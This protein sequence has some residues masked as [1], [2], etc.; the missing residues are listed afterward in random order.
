MGWWDSKVRHLV[1]IAR[2]VR[3]VKTYASGGEFC[4]YPPTFLWIEPTNR[5]NLR[6]VMCPTSLRKDVETGFME[7]T[8][9]ERIIDEA[10]PFVSGVNLFLGGE[11]LLHKDIF[12]M[13]RYA[14]EKGIQTRLNTNATLLNEKRARQLLDSGLDYLL[15]SFDGYDKESYERIRVNADFEDTLEKVI[16]FCR[17]KAELG[18][19]KPY[20]VLQSVTVYEEQETSWKR[21]EFRH[22]FDGLL[23]DQFLVR[24]VHSW[25]G[26][27]AKKEDFLLKPWGKRYNPCPF[28][29]NTMS[30]LWDGT[31]VPC[32]LDFWGVYPAGHVTNASLRDLWNGEPLLALRRSLAHEEYEGHPLCGKCELLW[33]E[34][35]ILGLPPSLLKVVL[36]PPLEGLL[37]YEAVNRAKTLLRGGSL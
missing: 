22:R 1:N 37:G 24:E 12:R 15:F 20:T 13:I 5:C 16:G 28:I 11:S 2:G 31:V 23:I 4:A 14:T 8:L 36:S 10:A 26:L 6:C 30:I 21:E 9:Y 35:R 34:R 7:W 29:W 3:A 33:E 32:C 17:L 19:R 27:F 25:R 18:K